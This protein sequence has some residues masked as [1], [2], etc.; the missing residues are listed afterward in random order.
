MKVLLFGGTGAMGRS[1][2]NFLLQEGDEVDI[3]TR[4]SVTSHNSSVKYI[5]GDAHS[6]D[7]ITPILAKHY[8]VIIDFM[9]YSTKEFS[10]R[11]EMFLNNTGLY[12]FLS[13]A[14][15]YAN[16]NEKLTENS[17]RLLDTDIDSQYLSSD[18]YALAK[19]RQENMLFSSPMK[20]WLIIRPYITYNDNRLQFGTYEKECWLYRVLHGQ[21]VVFLQDIF[22][23]FT[24]MTSGVDVANI[25]CKLSHLAISNDVFHVTTNESVKWKEIWNIYAAAVKKTKGYAPRLLL[26]DDEKL[27]MRSVGNPCQL[28]YDRMFNRIFDNTKVMKHVGNYSF[29]KIEIGLTNALTSFL[30][31]TEIKLYPPAKYLAYSDKFSRE[32][33]NIWELNSLSEIM[34]YLYHRFSWKSTT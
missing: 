20:N 25:I 13:S 23:R 11:Y 3:T 10:A 17:P 27:Y 1:L 7:F 33:S 15:V 2:V 4:S 6:L 18:E 34:K 26:V 12:V 24:T 22:E 32:W 9:V 8:D 31:H 14:R 29:E 5:Q 19:A 28:Q 16:C 21:T 30:N